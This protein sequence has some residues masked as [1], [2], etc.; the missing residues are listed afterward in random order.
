M[1]NLEETRKS[2]LGEEWYKRLKGE[3]EK[4]YMIR[5][6]T[7]LTKEYYNRTI[8]P[9]KQLLFRALK[10]T[11]FNKVKVVIIG[12]D[13][14]YN[15]KA[16]GLAFGYDDGRLSQYKKGSLEVIFDEIERDVKFGLYLE[17]NATLEQWAEQGVL[18]LNTVLS[19]RKGEANSHKK[20][21]WQN[22]TSYIVTLLMIQSRPLVVMAWGR[23]AEGFINSIPNPKQHLILKAP[24]PA[25]DLYKL[26]NFGSLEPN[27][28][29][30]F[31]GCN[32]F[33]QCNQYLGMKG[34]EGINW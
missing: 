31:A 18:L 4:P 11:P 20:I 33:S 17:G 28:P 9:E 27:Y 7:L 12:Q 15:G 32:H 26:N 13:P 21:G 10:D 1:S 22:F 19:V 8:Y 3:F 24:H 34:I 6:S 25:A 14:Y 16:N 30:T 5:L 23:E 2:L 29:Y